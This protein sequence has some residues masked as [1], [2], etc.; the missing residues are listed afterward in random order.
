M[1]LFS[2]PLLAVLSSS[3]ALAF[4]QNSHNHFHARGGY[5]SVVDGVD[6]APA[7]NQLPGILP[8]RNNNASA[9]FTVSGSYSEPCDGCLSGEFIM[10]CSCNKIVIILSALLT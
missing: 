9:D 5:G 3:L 4:P 1:H 7:V 10:V 2:I 6:S 8:N